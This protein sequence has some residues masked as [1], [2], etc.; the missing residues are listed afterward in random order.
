MEENSIVR[1]NLMNQEGYAPYCGSE[2]CAP[3]TPQSPDRWPRTKWIEKLNQ[4]KCPKCGWTSQYPN[5]FI[6]RYK[7]KWNK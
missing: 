2:L 7:K 4:F 1:N 3:R 5:D 6:A